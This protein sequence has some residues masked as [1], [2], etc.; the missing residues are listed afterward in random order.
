MRN[1]VKKING[2]VSIKEVFMGLVV[3]DAADLPEKV[4]E[5]YQ[6]EITPA[7]LDWPEGERLSGGNIYQKMREADKKGIKAFP[8]TSQP[9]PKAYLDAFQK[10]LQRFGKVFCITISSKLSGC[11]NSAK[12]AKT[13][14]KESQQVSILDSLNISA[15]QS[16]LVLRVIE[17]IQEQRGI[18]EIIQEL[19]NLIPKVHLYM[20]FEDPKW[21]E[22]SGRVTKSQANWMRRMKKNNLVPLMELKDG[23]FTKGGMVRARDISEALFKKIAKESKMARRENKEIRVVISHAD[24]LKGAEELREMLKGKINAEV[25]F[26]SLTAPAVGAR[27][28]PGSLVVG[29]MAM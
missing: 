26:I 1:V 17:F 2:E 14:V 20:Y 21:I 12:L 16:L 19:K 25:P 8:K 6:V 23:F 24:N 15:G 27:L 11:Y 5:K 9:V 4:L 29:W 10:Q 13:M 18:D 7:I 22:S 3:E 28:G